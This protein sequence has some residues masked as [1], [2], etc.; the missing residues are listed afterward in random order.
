[1]ADRID[2][3]SKIALDLAAAGSNERA[4]AVLR[5]QEPPVELCSWHTLA[6][7]IFDLAQAH[8]TLGNVSDVERLLERL[9]TFLSIEVRR[10]DSQLWVDTEKDKA[11][12]AIAWATIGHMEHA[13]ALVERIQI[14]RIRERVLRTLKAIRE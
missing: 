12:A 1:M 4:Y 7:A 9:D 5:D 3:S 8:T 13:E 2:L 10:E 11:A 6:G 14:A